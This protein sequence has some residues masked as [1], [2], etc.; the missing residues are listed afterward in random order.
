MNIRT[1]TKLDLPAMHAIYADAVVHGIASFDEV[2][3]CE[4]DFAQKF[5]ILVAEGFPVYVAEQDGTVLG[6]AYAGFYRPRSAYRFT[7]E[8]SIYI[9]PQA[10]KQGIGKVLMQNLIET[11]SAAGFK[12]MIAVIGGPEPA[13]IAL[14]LSC[15]FTE[16]GRLPKLGYKHD[17][18]LDIVLT[19]RPL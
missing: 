1:Y 9:A 7:I 4:I 3:P 10:K 13:S 8:N 19:Q 14:H 2:P 11:C 18:W 12:Q 15:G 5:K 6:Y 16:V 17:S